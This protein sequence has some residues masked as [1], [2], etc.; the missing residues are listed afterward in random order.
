MLT[1]PQTPWLSILLPTRARPVQATR[2]LTSLLTT[3]SDPGGLEVLLYIDED[4]P[5]SLGIG[6]SGLQVER[7]L[8]PP[9]LGLGVMT[10]VLYRAAKAPY[11]LLCGDDHVF[12][13]P[14]WDEAVRAEFAR[15]PDDVALVYGNDLFQGEQ[16][17]TAPFLSRTACELMGGPC[18]AVYKSSYIDTH[19]LDIFAHLEHLGHKRR[20][21]LPDMV[22]E[23]LHHLAGKAELDATYLNRPL[24]GEQSQA[25]YL[26]LEPM[27]DRQIKALARHIRDCSRHAGPEGAPPAA[28]GAAPASRQGLAS[29]G[30]RA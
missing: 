7:H 12:R 30:Q 23:H 2:L 26:G 16:I 8:G 19:L 25:L 29:G 13:T 20:I 9:G 15:F 17:C 6:L 10:N 11:I 21:Y 28:R 24:S 5:Q 4:D 1:L 18:P 3:A 27:R 14:G 22:I